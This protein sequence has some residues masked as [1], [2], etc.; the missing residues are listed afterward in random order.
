MKAGFAQI[1]IT[2]DRPVWM[3]GYSSRDHQSEGV[4]QELRAGAIALS[5]KG[6]AALLLTADVIGYSLA[7]SAGAKAM[8]ADATGL[9][10]DQII[11]TATHT[12]CAPFFYEW[13]M[14]G[15]VERE[16]AA[17]FQSKLVEVSLRAMKDL[18]PAGVQFT[19][20][21]SAFGVN[22][23]TPDGKGGV[24]FKANPAG[25]M[26]RDLD[27]LWFRAPDGEIR[28]TFTVYGCHST[29]RG[30]YLLGGDYPGFLCRGMTKHTDAPAFFAMGCGGN[31]RP[32][33]MSEKGFRAAEVE[34]IQE[35]G[36]RMT[37]EVIH[38]L[39]NRRDIEIRTIDVATAFHELHY[40]KLP[41]KRRLK[42]IINGENELN[43]IWANYFWERLQ[44]GPLPKS[45]P[46]EIQVLSLNPDFRLIFMGGEILTEIGLHLK[47]AFAPATTIT[48]GYS[49]GLIAYV[50]GRETYDLGGY[51]VEGSYPYF[52]RPAP[53]KKDV[54]DRIVSTALALA[55]RQG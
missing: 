4:Y 43:K 8:I 28:G 15:E 23:R 17:E 34:E 9:L 47:E 31:I 48:V 44:N 40:K 11:L 14:M 51:E 16:W 7:F 20:G 50:P 55:G 29:C 33:F 1:D 41:G 42:E 36:E 21:T 24:L 5:H 45:C 3:V 22:R 53:F 54:E 52:L 26:D 10:P 38:S 35:V 30:E 25:P 27:T 12:H 13:G 37:R 39:Q 6:G 2:P 32:D 49:N 46:Q 19:R 18:A